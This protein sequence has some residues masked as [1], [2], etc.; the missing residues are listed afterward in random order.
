MLLPHRSIKLPA[1]PKELVCNPFLYPHEIP[2][3]KMAPNIKKTHIFGMAKHENIG[4]FQNTEVD[5]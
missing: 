4:L 1:C 2:P 3:K 5:I